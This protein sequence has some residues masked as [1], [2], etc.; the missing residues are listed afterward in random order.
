MG[1]GA[2]PVVMTKVRSQPQKA[3]EPKTK[4]RPPWADRL[5]SARKLAGYD[6]R[7]DFAKAL[8]I[9]YETYSRY[10]RGETEPR[11]ATWIKV[12]QLT[13]QTID[14]IF[15]NARETAAAA[16]NIAAFPEKVE[17]TTT[18]YLQR[19]PQMGGEQKL[20]L[21]PTFCC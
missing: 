8:N 3:V 7:E 9:E 5:I 11:I 19:P 13:G 15:L 16:R 12:R 6:Q 20:L 17:F 21:R 14:S 10:E 2:H 4:V 18:L 1:P